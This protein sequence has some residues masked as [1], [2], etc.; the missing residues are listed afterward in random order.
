[1]YYKACTKHFPVLLCTTKLAQSRSQYYCV[2][3]SLHQSTSQYYCVLQSLLKHVPVLLCATK[4]A[5]TGSSTTVYYKA[6]TKSFPVLLCTTKLAQ[7]RSRYYCVLQSLHK[8]LPSTLCTTK[9]AQSTSPST[10]MYY[11]A[12]TKSFAVLLCIAKLAQSRSQYYCVLQ[13]L[14]KHVPST[15]VHYKACTKSFP[16]LLCTAKLAPKHFPVL[17]CTIKLEQS[18]SQYYCV[19][20]S[21]HKALPS[22]TVY[23]KACT[24]TFPVL[25]CTTKLAQSRSQ[26]YFVQQSSHK[27]VPSTTVYYKACTKALPNTT[28]SHY[29]ILFEDYVCHSIHWWTSISLFTTA[30]WRHTIAYPNFRHLEQTHASRASATA[31]H[32][33]S[34]W[35]KPQK[36]LQTNP[37]NFAVHCSA[38]RFRCHH[39]SLPAVVIPGCLIQRYFEACDLFHREAKATAPVTGKRLPETYGPS[40]E[41]G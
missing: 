22:T 31:C 9:L 18:R 39:S 13:S 40:R 33:A 36:L 19:L 16:V 28:V 21:L 27:V 23:Y 5:Q 6:C 3:Q 20:Q 41:S 15:T 8:A 12:C 32:R 14:H 2:Q 29:C 10:T 25:L 7:S 24:N 1:V 17:L 11:K 4:L 35:A 26:Y 38:F 37:R 34:R 30:I